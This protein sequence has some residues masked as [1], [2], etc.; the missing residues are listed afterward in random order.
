MLKCLPWC[1]WLKPFP[2]LPPPPTSCPC[3]YNIIHTHDGYGAFILADHAEPG[4]WGPSADSPT[5]DAYAPAYNV[6]LHTL[7]LPDIYRRDFVTDFSRVEGMPVRG[8]G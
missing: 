7:S 1:A 2:P 8:R 6:S 5:S 3:R 4:S